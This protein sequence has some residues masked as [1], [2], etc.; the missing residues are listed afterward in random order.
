MEIK[1][2]FTPFPLEDDHLARRLASALLLQWNTLSEDVRQRILD[3]AG[4]IEDR[5]Y[6]TVQLHEQ[7]GAFVRK[8][9]ASTNA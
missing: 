2:N 5:D 1:P 7:I 9:V 3:Q 4:L 8:Y 6:Q